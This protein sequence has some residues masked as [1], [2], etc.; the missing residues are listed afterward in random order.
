MANS[1]DEIKKEDIEEKNDLPKNKFELKYQNWETWDLSSDYWWIMD[2]RVYKGKLWPWNFERRRLY[3][4]LGIKAIKKTR[5]SFGGS[6]GTGAYKVTPNSRGEYTITEKRER[7]HEEEIIYTI[8]ID[9]DKI[10]DI[11]KYK[12]LKKRIDNFELNHYYYT[13]KM[14]Q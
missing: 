12:D 6:Y 9:K 7:W 1:W 3:K 10:V 11:E 8:G 14:Y 4:M 13:L 2:L 5:E